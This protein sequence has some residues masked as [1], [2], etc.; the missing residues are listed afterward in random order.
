MQSHARK[1]YLLVRRRNKLIYGWELKYFL[2]VEF[3]GIKNHSKQ[4]IRQHSLKYQSCTY[5]EES[6]LNLGAREPRLK[7]HFRNVKKF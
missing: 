2:L 7:M 1:S 5:M 3:S 4:K 6:G